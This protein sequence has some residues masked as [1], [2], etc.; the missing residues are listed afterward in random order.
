MRAILVNIPSIKDPIKPSPGFAKKGLATRKL[1]IMGWCQASC[2][3]CSSPA[4]NSLRINREPFADA[5]EVQTGARLYPAADPALTLRWEGFEERLDAQLA[6][7]PKDG[8]WGAG[9]TCQFGQLV[10]NFSPWAVQS[11]LT[12]R[13]LEKCLIRTALRF[14]V[15][16]KFDFVGRPAFSSKW[17]E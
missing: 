15:L 17:K 13:A 14:R 2:R 10:D 3:Y 7:K 9:E 6:T 16:T 8:S 12:R 11:G 4:G 1:D 5:A